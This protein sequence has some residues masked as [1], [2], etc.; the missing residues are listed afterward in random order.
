M[1]NTTEFQHSVVLQLM[2]VQE[3]TCEL[4]HVRLPPVHP[5][6]TVASG[7]GKR[8]RRTIRNRFFQLEHCRGI[9]VVKCDIA[10]LLATERAIKS[11]VVVTVVF[12]S[13]NKNQECSGCLVL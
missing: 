3:Q 6:C 12:T 13:L 2:I 8:T 7:S 9:W 1:S 5:A 10:V 4:P 11:V